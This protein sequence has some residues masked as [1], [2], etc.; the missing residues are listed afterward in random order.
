MAKRPVLIL[1]GWSDES[2][3]FEPLSTFLKNNGFR[4]IDIWLADY[5]SMKDEITIQDIGQAMGNAI[6]SNGISEKKH[7]FDVVVHSTGGLIV[8]QY[9][10]HY[11][12]ERPER[13]PI[14][15][16][17]M[18][19]PAN[20]GSP[21]AG[22]GKS[23]LGR[24]IKGRKWDGLFQTGTQ[25]LN[26]LKLASPISWHMAELD[27]FNPKNKI[28]SPKNI[29]TTVLIG[30]DSYQGLSSIIHENG[31]DGTVRVST[32]NL[33]AT[34]L[35]LKF[36]NKDSFPK[37]EEVPLSYDPIAFGVLFGHN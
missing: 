18:L 16:L 12:R 37:V 15:H 3:S 25:V 20:F 28:F 27:L 2:N 31:S 35:K 19:A 4:V 13:C 8:R 9:L 21:L 26:A 30:T 14:K 1:H 29:Y 17:V 5:I 32:A 22:K 10:I 11:F 23:L 34:Y 36:T 24:L 33:N 7:S 6:K